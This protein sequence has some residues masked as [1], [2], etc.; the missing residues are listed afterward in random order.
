MSPVSL[1]EPGK[2][3]GESERRRRRR[4]GGFISRD[5][6]R[7]RAESSPEGQNHSRDACNHC[8]FGQGAIFGQAI[9]TSRPISL[10]LHSGPAISIAVLYTVSYTEA[11]NRGKRELWYKISPL[12][13]L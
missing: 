1:H 10:N 12:I 8:N 5:D 2:E 4:E 7:V 13:F 3:K 9:A 11:K 6:E